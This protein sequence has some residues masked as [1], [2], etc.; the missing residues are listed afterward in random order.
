MTN[1]AIPSGSTPP[2]PSRRTGAYLRLCGVAPDVAG[3]LA[4]EP[5]ATIQDE[6]EAW[7]ASLCPGEPGE[8]RLQHKA[9]AM[10]RVL[11]AE[12]PARWPAHFL[13]IPPPPELA[14]AVQAVELQPTRPLSQTGMTPK[15]IDLGRVSDVAHETWKT[16][17]TWPVLRGLTL[18]LLFTLLLGTVFYVVRF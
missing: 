9:R 7:A 6:L 12:V 8:S 1:P 11:L 10:A 13:R 18:W 5:V 14:A 4:G 16:Y 15:P 2:D 3:G 17:D